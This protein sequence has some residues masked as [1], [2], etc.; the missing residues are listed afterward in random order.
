[1]VLALLETWRNRYFLSADAVSY[2]DMS[3]GMLRGQNWHRLINGTWSPLYPALLG[4]FRRIFQPSDMQEIAFD[5]LLNIP[6]F[7]FAF[8]A[9][10]FLL[11]SV[12]REFI[13]ARSSDRAPLPRWAFL[14]LGYT[15]FIWASL[16][17]ITLESVRPDMLMS[18]VLYLAVALLVRM[19]GRQPSLRSY[20]LLG[21]VLGVSYLVKVAML[22]TGLI[23]LAASVSIVA[24]RRRAIPMAAC[25]AI[26]FFLVGSLYFIPLSSS[27]GHFTLGES[28]T[29]NYILYDD[30]ASPS[31]YLTN[32]GS[33]QGTPVHRTH[34]IVAKPPTYEFSTGMP[35]THPLRFDPSYWTAGLKPTFGLRNQVSAIAGNVVVLK[36]VFIQMAGIFLGF[37]ALLWFSARAH[38]TKALGEDWPLWL[39]GVAGVL[40]YVPVHVEPRYV[41]A[42]LVLFWL[43]LMVGLG[44]WRISPRV[45]GGIVIAVAFSLVVVTAKA[46]YRPRPS[47]WIPRRNVYAEVVQ[48][49][50]QFGTHAGDPVAR[51]ST[52]IDLGWA[53]EA[54]VTIIAEVDLENGARDFWTS[55]PAVQNRVLQALRETGARCVVAHVW[56]GVP[57]PGW[58]RVGQTQYWIYPFN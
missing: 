42:F 15:L 26:I 22:P 24:N 32:Q 8:A 46:A 6:I 11:S 37:L 1:M 40:M 52:G 17:E 49:L 3:D 34:Q 12:D 19:R 58:Y 16:A 14:A 13:S 51:I 47:H 9:F 43:G 21:V 39:V 4:L 5:H 20:V 7:L 18:G 41:G 2:M 30:G 31:W 45:I 29:F 55:D 28:G 54:R 23:I 35:I 25:S 48:A 44:G 50:R 53:R 38:L 57:F 10:E 27:L 56:A 36:D 33:A